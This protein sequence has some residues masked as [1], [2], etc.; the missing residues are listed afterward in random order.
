M[1][2]PRTGLLPRVLRGSRHGGRLLEVPIFS[3]ALQEMRTYAIWLPPGY[4]RSAQPYPVVFLLRGHHVEWQRAHRVGDGFRMLPGLPA[5]RKVEVSHVLQVLVRARKVRP[6]LVVMPCMSNHDGTLHGLATDWIAPQRARGKQR[7]G[8]GTGRFG[9]HLMDEIV[10]HVDHHFHTIPERRGRATDGFSL[11]GFMALKLA[12]ARPELFSAVGAYDGSFFYLHQ[13]PGKMGEAP[14][15]LVDH[16]LF[17]PIF[18]RPRCLEHVRRNSPAVL[19]AESPDWALQSTRFF[20]Q[21]GPQQAE[22]GDSNFYRTM[23]VTRLLQMRGVLN[24]AYPIV[25]EDGHHDWPTAYRHLAQAL[26][27]FSDV[28][29]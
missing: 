3:E 13:R 21:C 23:H 29:G 14:D 24:H 16:A 28:L 18:D 11:G 22:P 4:S 5:M 2:A 1:T 12:L 6:M 8:V 19:L 7:R 15:Y 27:S 17:D 10:P 20:L 26:V 25:L 9:A